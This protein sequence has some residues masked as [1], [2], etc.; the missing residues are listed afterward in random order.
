MFAGKHTLLNSGNINFLANWPDYL[1]IY[2]QYMHIIRYNLGQKVLRFCTFE[3]RIWYQY[4]PS[5]RPTLV[6]FVYS[7]SEMI[8]PGFNIFFF[9]G[10]G[11]G[12][13]EYL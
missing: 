5:P 9:G 11:G 4:G 6:K 12:K 2:R 10:R 7:G 13:I 3:P 1:I 8:Q